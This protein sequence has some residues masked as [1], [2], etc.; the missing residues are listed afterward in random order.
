M[1]E[2]GSIFLKKEN[3]IVEKQSVVGVCM[4]F[5]TVCMVVVFVL[6][7]FAIKHGLNWVESN[8]KLEVSIIVRTVLYLRIFV[9]TLNFLSYLLTWA[10]QKVSDI[11][12]CT[13]PLIFLTWVI[14]ITAWI[15]CY[16]WIKTVTTADVPDSDFDPKDDY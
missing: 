13:S 11:Y 7:I 9:S 10:N 14:T 1:N 8:G 3:Q 15:F 16:S 2:H 12:L 5:W 4:A 6:E